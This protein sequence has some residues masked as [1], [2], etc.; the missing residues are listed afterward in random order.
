MKEYDSMSSDNLPKQENFEEQNTDEGRR[1]TNENKVLVDKYLPEEDEDEESIWDGSESEVIMDDDARIYEDQ[2]TGIKI[3]YT[4]KFE[5]I[6]SC[7]KLINANQKKTTGNI[8][9]T[10]LLIV[11]GITFFISYF[12]NYNAMNLIMAVVC[13]VLTVLIFT[14]P[15]MVQRSQ[16]KLFMSNES[17]YVEIYPDNIVVGKNGKEREIALDGTSEYI[18]YE[19]LFIIFPPNGELVIIPERSIEPDFLPDVQAMLI[20]GTEPRD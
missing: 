9:K 1:S 6:L 15:K 13:T 12:M 2:Q 10:V 4:L 14:V 19:N 5:E 17:T 11:F 8:I 18:E 3:D 20:A 7:L 16:A